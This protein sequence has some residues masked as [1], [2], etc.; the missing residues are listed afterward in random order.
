VL[1]A[2]AASTE[3]LELQL[4]KQLGEAT[5]ETWFPKGLRT[6]PAPDAGAPTIQPEKDSE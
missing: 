2:D 4:T 6:V 1:V 3:P 5:V